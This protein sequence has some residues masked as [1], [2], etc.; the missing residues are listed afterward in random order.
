MTDSIKFE[1][2]YE[3]DDGIE[4][5]V[6]VS[7]PAEYVVCGCCRG[8]GRYVNRNI[9]GNGITSSEWSE[10][11]ADNEDFAENYMSGVYD[12]TCEECRG[13]RV[14]LEVVDEKFLTE[15]QKGLSKKYYDQLQFDA[16]Y[17]REEAYTRRMESGGY[18]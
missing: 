18:E 15:E 10:L 17:D 3:D 12:V 6:E 16:E 4:I 13:L 11:C 8:K 14:V 5:E 1:F 7:L 9:D 2:E